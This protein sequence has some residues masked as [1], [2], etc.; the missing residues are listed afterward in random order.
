MSAEG[1]WKNNTINILTFW[2]V[3]NYGA[4]AQAYALRNVISEMY[5]DYNVKQI[6]YLHPEHKKMYFTKRFP[7]PT[8]LSTFLHPAYYRNLYEYFFKDTTK[9]PF[10]DSAWDSIPHFKVEDID[11]LER[12]E[13]DIL[14]TGSDVVWQFGT[15]LFGDDTH[16]IGI[17]MKY[18]KL[19]AYA[20]SFGDL[21]A[22]S[23]HP[24][25][26]K[27]GL[28]KYHNISVRDLNS[29]VIVENYLPERNVPIVLDPTLLYDFKH[30]ESI[31]NVTEKKYILVYGSVPLRMVV[32]IKKYARKNKLR[33]IGTGRSKAPSWCNKRLTDI[34]PR[35]W[36]GLFKNAEFV[37]T[38]TFHGLMFSII[39]EKRF[40]FYQEEYVKNRSQWILEKL[41]LAE[42][43]RLD[44]LSLKKVLDF[45]WKYEDYNEIL[46][47]L[48]KES[49]NYLHSLA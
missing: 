39:Y 27:N 3:P 32:E 4:W 7:K 14:V 40:L 24:S 42:L 22:D 47:E 34:G 48:R 23:K 11:S 9:Y 18:H 37:V 13:S 28:S 2:G 35:E 17:G 15:S 6:A 41:G 49:L 10:F 43:F 31:P 30:D 29:K 16:L 33:I 45:N 19:I 46:N 26:I 25:F 1:N 38:S 12:I 44:T 21:N 8:S 5:P 20:C 36:I